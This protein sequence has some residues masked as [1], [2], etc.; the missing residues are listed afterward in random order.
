MKPSAASANDDLDRKG[1]LILGV[2][3]TFAVVWVL[4]LHIDLQQGINSNHREAENALNYGLSRSCGR[5]CCRTISIVKEFLM[6]VV[7]E[8]LSRVGHRSRRFSLRLRI[9]VVDSLATRR[10]IDG[11]D[12]SKLRPA[13]ATLQAIANK[14]PK[15]G[16]VEEKYVAMYNTALRDIQEQL[17]CDLS[18]FLIPESELEH[19][20]TSFKYYRTIRER[21]R[22]VP[23]KTYSKERYCDRAQ[24][25]IALDGASN[26]IN[27]YLQSPS[28]LNLKRNAG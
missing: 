23:Q 15:S 2:V 20:L 6:H 14:L 3:W 17:G 13:L 1:A 18:A 16:D 4:F 25:D 12:D 22:G 5:A 26:L 9:I 10:H 24:F 8:S 21:Q 27:S 7:I 11:M 28:P 19:H